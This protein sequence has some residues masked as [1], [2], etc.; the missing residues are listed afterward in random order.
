MTIFKTLSID[1]QVEITTQIVA[2]IVQGVIIEREVEEAR[3][4]E[5]IRMKDKAQ[6]LV[7]K[8][9]KNNASQEQELQIRTKYYLH[10]KEAEHIGQEELAQRR[11]GENLEQSKEDLREKRSKEKGE[12]DKNNKQ[13]N[14][15]ERKR[16]KHPN[17]QKK[18][19]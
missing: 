3:R 9:E 16:K 12:M 18:L 15:H 19:N 11:I 6:C 7:I 1:K 14:M 5:E 10:I 2:T 8:E 13:R 4:A 17:I